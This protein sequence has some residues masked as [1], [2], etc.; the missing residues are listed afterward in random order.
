MKI[1]RETWLKA[2][3]EAMSTEE[4]KELFKNDSL[5]E[6][7]FTD[8]SFNLFQIL[9]GKTLNHVEFIDEVADFAKEILSGTGIETTSVLVNIALMIFANGIW[10]NMIKLTESEHLNSEYENF[11]SVLKAQK[12][13]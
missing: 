4:S 2:T 13:E 10:E 11:K 7:L 6:N 5:M 8:Y 1:T 12:S 9:S 3:A